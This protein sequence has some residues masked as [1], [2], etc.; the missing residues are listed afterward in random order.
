MTDSWLFRSELH[1]SEMPC[2]RYMVDT[3]LR[4][5]CGVIEIHEDVE[6][7]I[8]GQ[9]CLNIILPKY[10]TAEI[11]LNN[12]TSKNKTPMKIKIL[13]ILAMMLMAVPVTQAQTKYLVCTLDGT[14]TNSQ[15]SYDENSEITQDGI[16]WVVTG[17]TSL[18]PWRIGGSKITGV[19]RP[20]YSMDALDDTIMEV[21]VDIGS[22]SRITVNSFTLIVASDAAFQN[23]IDTKN[24]PVTSN[25]TVSFTPTAGKVWYNAYYKFVF[26]VTAS[27]NNNYF[28]FTTANFY[29]ATP[30]PVTSVTLNQNTAELTMGDKLALTATVL[31]VRATDKSVTWTSSDEA[32]ATVSTNGTVTANAIGTATITVTTTDGSLSAACTVTVNSKTYDVTLSEDTEDADN[33]TIDPTAAYEGQTVTVTYNGTKRVKDLKLYNGT[34]LSMVDNAGKER[35]SRWTANCYMVQT[36]GDYKLPLVYGNAIKD[37]QTNAA[38]YTGVTDNDLPPPRWQCHHLPVD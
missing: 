29:A 26:N 37:G 30:K 19:D 33:W 2:C 27:G 36:A 5:L 18:E 25:S 8:V 24:N 34:D 28:Q 4:Y 10:N 23:V 6:V 15:S 13:S 35:N 3:T 14:Q 12:N 11:N 9:I 7:I 32:V 38:A 1:L 21:T 20:I 31:P 17:N 16:T 22:R